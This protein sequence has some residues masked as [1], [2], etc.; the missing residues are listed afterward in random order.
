[1]S[2]P[3]PGGAPAQLLMSGPNS[4][5][6]GGGGPRRPGSTRGR[7][8]AAC[9]LS[10]NRAFP[11]GS[12]QQ[13]RAYLPD[14]KKLDPEGG[15]AHVGV[16]LQFPASVHGCAAQKRSMGGGRRQRRREDFKWGRGKNKRAAEDADGGRDGVREQ[17]EGC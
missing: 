3:E 11:I 15:S 12:V 9:A 8:A 10:K 2:L 16:I 7:A 5:G 4:C 14:F 6:V 17:M 1:M 13:R